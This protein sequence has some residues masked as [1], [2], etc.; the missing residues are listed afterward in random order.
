MH[1]L[2]L[3]M[4]M[5]ACAV[6]LWSSSSAAYERAISLAPNVT[7]LI[8]AIGA[9]EALVATVKSSNYP[10]AALALPRVGDGVSVSAETV[11]ALQPDVIFAWQPTRALVAL[12]HTLAQSGVALHYIH[13]QS[14]NEIADAA[15]QLGDWLNQ[16]EKAA[17]LSQQWQQQVRQLEQTYQSPTPKTVFIALNSTPLY[18]LNDAIS[19]DVLRVCGAQNWAQHHQTVV[20]AVNVEQLFTAPIDGIIYTD[21]DKPLTRLVTLLNTTQAQP[22][23]TYQVDADQFYRAGPRLFDATAALCAQIAQVRPHEK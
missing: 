22:A 19:N 11:L 3:V 16:P 7:E 9:E 23:A 6:L 21:M 5:M 1:T 12:E 20:P 17:A 10:P 14:L 15:L 13:P 18:T 2:S 4:P 8:Y